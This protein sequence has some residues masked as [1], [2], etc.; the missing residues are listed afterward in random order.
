M[1]RFILLIAVLAHL[2]PSFP[3]AIA[4]PTAMDLVGKWEGMVEFSK[5][6]FTMFLRV[7]KTEEGRLAVTMDVPEQGQKGIPVAAILFNSPEVRIEVDQFQTA[8]N[9][10]LSDDLSE[11][12]GE[13]EEGPGG[14]PIAV[15]FK[16][17]TATD[18]I[19]P[20]G[21]FTFQPGEARDLRG[22]WKG[23]LEPMPGRT[24]TFGLNVGRLPEGAFRAKLDVL[25]RGAKGIPAS[26]A[27]LSNNAVEVK[28]EALQ[29]RFAGKLSEDANNIPGKWHEG[30]REF[31]LTFARLDEPASLLPKNISFTAETNNPEDIRGEWSGRLNIPTGKIRLIFKIG[32]TPEGAFAGILTSPDQGPGE[33]PLSA[34]SFTAPKVTL[35]WKALNAKFEG[36]LTNNGAALE[37][38]WEQFGNKTPLKVERVALTADNKKS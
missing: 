35:E 1:K 17:S 12:R 32:K 28:W 22:H 5:F 23:I 10:K 34:A 8:Y 25:D 2:L 7:A 36:T 11:I 38:T 18:E 24:F 4:A 20:E 29:I 3:R 6:K 26:S 19:E 30:G 16:R 14:R 33:L 27:T 13:F 9:G 15:T 31:D 37:G 21:I